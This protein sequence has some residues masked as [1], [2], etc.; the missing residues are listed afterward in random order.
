[1]IKLKS[2]KFSNR[3]RALILVS[4]LLV[5]FAF[6]KYWYSKKSIETK[7]MIAKLTNL[8]NQVSMQQK[9]LLQIQKSKKNISLK[10]SLKSQ[11]EKHLSSSRYFSN[12]IA[13]LSFEKNPEKFKIQK[14]QV[15]KSTKF[16]GYTKNKIKLE[17]QSS[18]IGLGEFLEELE[19]SKYLVEVN[20]I[21]L[22]KLDDDLLKCT[23]IVKVNS[24]TFL[25]EQ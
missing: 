18:F 21:K 2:I 1:M 25:R 4:F 11:L 8:I 12:L 10:S 24:Y 13:E 17:I 3:E 6:N 20:S 5:S 23:S 15:E 16:D 22:T 19:N 9:N 14:I 7:E